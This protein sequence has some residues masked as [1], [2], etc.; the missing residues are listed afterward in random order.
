MLTL[1]QCHAGYLR[2]LSNEWAARLMQGWFILQAAAAHTLPAAARGQGRGG[3]SVATIATDSAGFLDW[4]KNLQCCQRTAIAHRD[5]ASHIGLTIEMTEEQAYA[6]VT[7]RLRALQEAQQRITAKLLLGD[8]PKPKNTTTDHKQPP[9]QG[10]FDFMSHISLLCEDEGRHL[11]ELVQ[12]P[13]TELEQL[14]EKTR[15]ALD[16][17]KEAKAARRAR[18]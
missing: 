15:L 11:H 9:G 3:K 16:K 6:H 18:K 17:I 8:A 13:L 1:D 12:L 14:E 2:H 5:I 7:E 4:L 10:W